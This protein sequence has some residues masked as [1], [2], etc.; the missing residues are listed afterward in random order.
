MGCHSEP[1]SFVRRRIRVA[2]PSRS[3][4]QN[5]RA[6]GSLRMSHAILI[7]DDSQFVRQAL[8]EKFDREDGSL[9]AQWRIC[10]Q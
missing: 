6:F 9:I 7:A 10:E 4:R 3:L 8:C 5:I 2:R 1:A